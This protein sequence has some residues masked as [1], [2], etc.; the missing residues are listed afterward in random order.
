M[1][2]TAIAAVAITAL[3]VALPEA[4]IPVELKRG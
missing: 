4:I 1:T 2:R 3:A